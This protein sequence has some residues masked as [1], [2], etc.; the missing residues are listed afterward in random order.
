[1][2]PVSEALFEK[3]AKRIREKLLE[4]LDDPEFIDRVIDL[5]DNKLPVKNIVFHFQH[6]SGCW[7]LD[8][9]SISEHLE[10]RTRQT[11]LA[12]ARGDEEFLGRLKVSAK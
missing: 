5:H 11:K 8:I 7:I 3:A 4:L 2:D 10:R 12:L 6:F 1:M 9:N